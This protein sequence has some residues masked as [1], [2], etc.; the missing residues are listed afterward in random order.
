MRKI[1]M[2]PFIVISTQKSSID[3]AFYWDKYSEKESVDGA[4]YWDKQWEK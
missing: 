4:V 3:G 1:Y 2:M